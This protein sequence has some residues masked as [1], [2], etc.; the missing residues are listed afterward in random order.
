MMSTYPTSVQMNI[1]TAIPVQ[2]RIVLENDLTD[3]TDQNYQK[4]IGWMII[5]CSVDISLP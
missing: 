4:Y 5:P 3:P 1:L 2:T